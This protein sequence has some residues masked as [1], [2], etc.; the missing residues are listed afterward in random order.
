MRADTH[1]PKRRRLDNA[2]REALK[3]RVKRERGYWGPL[4]E[5]VF[6]IDAS[7]L[8]TYLQLVTPSQS[9]IS[10]KL[11][12][13]IYIAVDAS[14]THLYS[15]GILL[16]IELAMNAGATR[17]EVFA[18]LKLLLGYA[19]LPVRT[20]L[21][22]LQEELARRGM[23]PLVAASDAARQEELKAAFKS[24]VGHWP[25][26]FD[27]LFAAAP[28]MAE[29]LMAVAREPWRDDVLDARSK[30]LILV[31]TFGAPTSLHELSLRDAI[32]VA[33]AHGV[34]A[35]EIAEAL[36]LAGGIAMHAMSVAAPLLV[37]H[38]EGEEVTRY[39]VGDSAS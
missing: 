24:D 32:G 22:I 16:H 38:T 39:E 7:F 10:D 35:E 21:P 31:A 5:C 26:W 20:G 30:A 8:E 12:H 33:L 23:A 3:A 18:V 36:Q 34:D 6:R 27:S 29:S 1:S 14:V 9:R 2:E 37:Q 13:L 15:K 19:A 17:E 25:T 4:Q 11:R 28:A